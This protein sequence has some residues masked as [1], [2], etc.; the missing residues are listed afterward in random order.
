MKH[1][2]QDF[3]VTEDAAVRS[4]IVR[5]DLDQHESNS[6]PE[7]SKE[8]MKGRGCA[9]G[10]LSI[11]SSELS[12]EDEVAESSAALLAGC[13]GLETSLQDLPDFGIIAHE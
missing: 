12:R 5:S 7:Q 1:H 2:C 9:R 11:E 3:I 6:E 4:P 8:S 10:I 13:L